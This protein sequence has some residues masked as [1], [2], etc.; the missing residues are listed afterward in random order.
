MDIVEQLRNESV[1]LRINPVGMRR[2]LFRLKTDYAKVR[3]N[4][5]REAIRSGTALDSRGP[6][7]QASTECPVCLVNFQNVDLVVPLTCNTEHVFHIECLLSWADHNY[8]CP[9]CRQPIISSQA[10]INLYEI[11]HQR[12]QLNQHEDQLGSGVLNGPAVVVD[13]ADEAYEV[14]V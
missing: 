2:V 10:E 5:L 3:R 7:A 6:A 13:E 14:S 1:D 4:Q 12:N 9:I 8:T 11:M